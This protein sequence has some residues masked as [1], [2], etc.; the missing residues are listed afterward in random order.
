M[1][2]PRSNPE[3]RKRCGPAYPLRALQFRR[4]LLLLR[5]GTFLVPPPTNYRRTSMLAADHTRQ[6]PIAWKLAEE[7]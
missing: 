3:I 1:R 4:Q 2:T 6:Q 7:F 5:S